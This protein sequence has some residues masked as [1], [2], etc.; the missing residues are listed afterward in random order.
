MSSGAKKSRIA[1]NKLSLG[2]VSERSV[3]D[4]SKLKIK[5][6]LDVGYSNRN[7]KTGKKYITTPKSKVGK[8]SSFIE[9][10]QPS[11]VTPSIGG[12]TGGS[13][14]ISTAGVKGITMTSTLG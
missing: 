11:L 1:T 6:N 5:A 7:M 3:K 10:H 2:G 13:K 8:H 4:K 12:S 14:M 9:E